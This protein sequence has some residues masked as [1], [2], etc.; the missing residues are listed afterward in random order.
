VLNLLNEW[1]AN[2][3]LPFFVI[4]MSKSLVVLVFC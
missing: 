3:L 4:G 2:L 1:I